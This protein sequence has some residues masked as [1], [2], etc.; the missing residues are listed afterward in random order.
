MSFMVKRKVSSSVSA[1]KRVH[2]FWT[3]RVQGVGFR[4]TTRLICHPRCFR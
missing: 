1:K 3:G 2:V 4:Y